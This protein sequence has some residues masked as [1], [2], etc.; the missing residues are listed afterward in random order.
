MKREWM[1][2]MRTAI[3]D[4]KR[5]AWLRSNDKAQMAADAEAI[6]SVR[7][8]WEAERKAGTRE[9]GLSWFQV[10]EMFIKM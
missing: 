2:I 10:G 3:K 8:K 7:L 1:K 9:P 6:E 4:K 5:E